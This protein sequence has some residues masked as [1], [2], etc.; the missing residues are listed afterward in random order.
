MPKIGEDN[1]IKEIKNKDAQK[2]EE[3]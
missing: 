3:I 2:V 1:E